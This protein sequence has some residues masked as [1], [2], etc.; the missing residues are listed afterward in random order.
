LLPF[1]KHFLES[2]GSQ[3]FSWIISEHFWRHS[4]RIDKYR[5][6]KY[7]ITFQHVFLDPDNE[8]KVWIIF[9]MVI[10]KVWSFDHI[11]LLQ[12]RI[13]CSSLPTL[14]AYSTKGNILNEGH[15]T[16]LLFSLLS[17]AGFKAPEKPWH[18]WKGFIISPARPEQ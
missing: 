18:L 9:L 12:G 4:T 16:C 14:G 8:W 7:E 15:V 2:K 10:F 3:R 13:Y 17:S 5:V 1:P 11:D 6:L